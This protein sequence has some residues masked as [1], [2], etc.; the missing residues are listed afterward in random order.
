MKTSD[1]YRTTT[2]LPESNTTVQFEL[3]TT[4]SDE[5]LKIIKS[6][7]NNCST[8]YDDIPIFLIKQYL[9]TSHHLLAFIIN[10]QILTRTFS[11]KRKISRIC[12]VT[13]VN[14]PETPDGYGPI[15]VSPILSKVYER[16]ILHQLTSYIKKDNI[17]I[18]VR[19]QKV[20]F[21][22]NYSL[23]NWRS[24][25]RCFVDFSKAF[26]TSDFN[27]LIHK[28]NSLH[29]SKNFLYLIL[30]SLSNRNRFV[31]IDSLCSNLWCSNIHNLV[32][33]KGQF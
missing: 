7:R 22:I 31:Q 21:E 15:S 25:F 17:S 13:K 16:I 26:D 11:K 20:L 3:H 29:F 23:K 4:N 32:Y 10:N 24:Y 27:I 9:N 1:V 14:I 28:L 2:S 6:L 5:V 12:P 30:N 33:H 8:G 18:S 19:I